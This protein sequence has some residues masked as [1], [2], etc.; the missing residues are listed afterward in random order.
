MKVCIIDK[1]LLLLE[2]LPRDNKIGT[3]NRDCDADKKIVND[4]I[5]KCYKRYGEKVI[6]DKS[7]KRYLDSK[8][9]EIKDINRNEFI[10]KKVLYD[11]IGYLTLIVDNMEEKKEYLY[12]IIDSENNNETLIPNCAL[13]INSQLFKYSLLYSSKNNKWFSLN[14]YK[15][16][17]KELILFGHVR[18]P[19]ILLDKDIYKDIKINKIFILSKEEKKSLKKVEFISFNTKGKYIYLKGYEDSSGN[20]L[21]HSN[22]LSRLDEYHIKYDYIKKRADTSLS[23]KEI[24]NNKINPNKSTK[25]NKK[26]KRKIDISIISHTEISKVYL[27]DGLRVKD[28]ND[29]ENITFIMSLKNGSIVEKN[30][31]YKKSKDK[32]YI[33]KDVLGDYKK[34]DLR[35]EIID[36]NGITIYRPNITYSEYEYSNGDTILS[37]CGY[38]ADANTYP[39][40]RRTALIRCIKEHGK[41]NTEATL[42]YLIRKDKNNSIFYK[43]NKKRNEDLEWLRKYTTENQREVKI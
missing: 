13:K 34:Y 36:N 12:Y 38:S 23:N 19:V 33:A 29:F 26:E 24:S 10:I 27:Y 3:F 6:Y 4:F 35:V 39:G 1:R 2:H 32:Y 17:V 43:A 8:M 15:C 16:N 11:V 20:Y 14:N 18:R 41:A 21:I 25:I 5:I 7:V 28:E 37:R 31:Y 30:G 40:E 9:Y 22:Q 42:S